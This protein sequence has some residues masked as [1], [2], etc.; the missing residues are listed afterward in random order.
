MALIVLSFTAPPA[1]ADAVFLSEGGC[2]PAA[3]RC[4]CEGQG[5]YALPPRLLP[6]AVA[7]AAAHL[8]GGSWLDAR[9][10]QLLTWLA[11]PPLLAAGTMEQ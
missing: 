8:R 5:V 6:S 1:A 7:A 3:V 4:R 9:A 10:L 2:G 11:I